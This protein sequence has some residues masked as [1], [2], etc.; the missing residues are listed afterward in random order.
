MAVQHDLSHYYRQREGALGL[1]PTLQSSEIWTPLQLPQRVTVFSDRYEEYLAAT[2]VSAR[3]P[4]GREREYGGI[5]P[6]SLPDDHRPKTEPPPLEAKGHKHY[7]YGGDPWPRGLPIEQ[8]YEITQLK[9]SDV[10]AS[11]D[12]EKRIYAEFPAEHPYHSHISKF[13]VFPGCEPS[14]DSAQRVSTP[15]PQRPAQP[16]NAIILRKTKGNPYRHEVIYIPPD[17]QKEPLSWPGQKGYFHLPKCHPE[18][19]QKY[20]PMPPKTVAPNALSRSPEDLLS[21]RTVNLQRNLLKSQ[22]ITSYNRNFT[23]QGEMNPLQLDN[24]D[25]M[26]YNRFMGQTD[27]NAE[28][29]QTFTSAILPARPLDGGGSCLQDGR[30]ILTMSD[31]VQQVGAEDH[32]SY[33]SKDPDVE[34]DNNTNL[35]KQLEN[36]TSSFYRNSR[37]CLAEKEPK[38]HSPTKKP[39][40]FHKITDTEQ[41]DALYRRQ[42]TPKPVLVEEIENPPKS[43]CYEDLPPNTCTN[44]MVS[45]TPISFKKSMIQSNHECDAELSK[46]LKMEEN[47]HILGSSTKHQSLRMPPVKGID[48]AYVTEMKRPRTAFLELQDTFSKSEKCKTFHQHFQEK[49]KDLR[50]NHYAGKKRTFYGFNSF[51]FHN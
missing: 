27:E 30:R 14:E 11:D 28:L 2:P 37:N 5:G 23:G 29:K 7:G 43:L 44:F 15:H 51:Y 38:H 34:E 8:Y 4:W 16:C 47:H 42:L 36:Y 48:D 46:T 50:E 41:L 21:D 6:V 13:A 40:C 12:F 25:Q 18:N 45:K 26:L 35:P 20:Y 49:P 24:F 19:K 3:L 17:S 22:W 9:K 39:I 10:R 32:S 1:S 33:S 31:E